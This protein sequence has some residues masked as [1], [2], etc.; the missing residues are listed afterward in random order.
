M[1]RGEFIS[2]IAKANGNLYDCSALTDGDL[3]NQV[4]VRFVCGKHGVFYT[5]PYQLLHGMVGCFEC[6]KEKYWGNIEKGSR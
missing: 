1:T 4:N 3:E 5:T 6:F 2:T